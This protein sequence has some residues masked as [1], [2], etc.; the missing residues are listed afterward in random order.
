MLFYIC[1]AFIY[2]VLAFISLSRIQSG[3]GWE[4]QFIV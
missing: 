1:I 3:F 4:E 2:A